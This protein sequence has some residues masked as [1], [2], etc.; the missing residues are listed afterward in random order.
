MIYGLFAMVG[1]V[2]GVRILPE[3]KNRSLEELEGIL[4]RT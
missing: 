2:I 3:T 1:G 4:V